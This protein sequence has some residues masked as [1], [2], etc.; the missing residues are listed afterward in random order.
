MITFG[1]QW[2]QR[3]SCLLGFL[4]PGGRRLANESLQRETS[5]GKVGRKRKG[6]GDDRV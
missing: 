2:R 6:E 4:W 1:G 5:R 3:R